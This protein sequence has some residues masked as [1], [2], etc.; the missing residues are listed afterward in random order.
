M[1]RKLAIG[2][3]TAMLGFSLVGGG[4]YAAFNDVE[5]A[6][7]TYTAGE[8]DLSV[9][10]NIIFDIDK[11]VPGD[12]MLRDFKITN[13]GNVDIEKVLM[14]TDYTV[15]DK[16]GNPIDED[17]GSQ[18]KVRL[19][20]SDLQPIITPFNSL[21]LSELKDLTESGNSPDITTYL[22]RVW[23]FPLKPNLPINDDDHIVMEVKFINDKQKDTNSGLYLQN[24]YQGLNLN[25]QFNLEATQYPGQNR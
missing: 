9:N 15:T 22:E 11:L 17:L 12:H 13:T 2:A 18:F 4:T 3:I 21:T 23:I 6:T 25:V 14:H 1:K 24:K 16:N 10:P 5:S 7:G 8:L 19:L 20:T